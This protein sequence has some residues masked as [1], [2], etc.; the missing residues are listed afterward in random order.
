MLFSRSI[1][2]NIAYGI[3]GSLPRETRD[4]AAAKANAANFIRAFPDGFQTA[5]GERGQQMSGK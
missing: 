4:A 2:E 1:E 3:N 5:A